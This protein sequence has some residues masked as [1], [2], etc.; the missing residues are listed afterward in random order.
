MMNFWWFCYLNS[1]GNLIFDRSSNGFLNV[2]VF[3]YDVLYIFQVDKYVSLMGIG[4]V[5]EG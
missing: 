4:K 1:L 3:M 2:D 5:K